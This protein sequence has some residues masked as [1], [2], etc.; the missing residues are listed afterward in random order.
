MRGEL[1]F[2]IPDDQEVMVKLV[3]A[4]PANWSWVDG[5]LDAPKNLVAS[6]QVEEN[7]GF[8]LRRFH[9]IQPTIIGSYDRNK[10]EWG[11][12]DLFAIMV[13]RKL[14]GFISFNEAGYNSC[15]V[16]L[17]LAKRIAVGF[18]RQGYCGGLHFYSGCCDN[19]KYDNPARCSLI[20]EPWDGVKEMCRE[21]AGPQP[22]R[23]KLEWDSQYYGKEE[24]IAPIVAVCRSLNLH[25]YV[26]GAL[27]KA[28]AL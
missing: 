2:K 22:A 20:F 27:A 26:P 25:Q 1:F 12:P 28:A 10:G 14:P 19:N 21:E 16:T 9:S 7:T 24:D 6:G 8:V 17:E 11:N 4:V 15:I 3:E 23:V 13:E 18:L 5:A